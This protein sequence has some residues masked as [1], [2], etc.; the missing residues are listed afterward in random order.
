MLRILSRVM[1][2]LLIFHIILQ[3][4]QARITEKK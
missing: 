4:K 2:K 3:R 1:L